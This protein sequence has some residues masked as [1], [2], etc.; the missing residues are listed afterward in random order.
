VTETLEHT[1]RQIAEQGRE[2]LLARLRPAFREAA[3]AH[4]DTLTLDDEQLEQMV[5]RAA[6]RADGLQWRRALASVA[7]E[8]LG[9]GLGEALSHPAVARAQEIVGAPSYEE[10]LS[11]LGSA[12]VAPAPPPAAAEAAPPVQEESRGEEAQAP[13][14]ETQEPEAPE[15]EVQ[16]PEVHE[17]EVQEPEVHE[18][19]AP[20]PEE[21]PQTEARE[22]EAPQPEAVETEAPDLEAPQ[23]EAL[24]TE[25][26]ES[27]MPAAGAEAEALAP[28]EPDTA[29]EPE[30]ES[31]LAA[32][33][34]EDED[35]EQ[36]DEEAPEDVID[37]PDAVRLRAVHL[38]GIAN[39]APAEGDLELHISSAGL[40]IMR[41]PDNAV[42]GRL[43]WADIQTLETPEASGRFRRKRQADAHLVVRSP[44]GTASFEIPGVTPA[45]LR[46]HIEPLVKAHGR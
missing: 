5:Q 16:E 7:T 14:P 4:R 25:P 31:E 3:A 15:P 13:E 32:T 12:P 33:E 20:E 23:P 26:S 9:I 8:Q 44:Q 27:E 21:A 24:E 29:A 2:A 17:P 45:E 22:T 40:D 41:G 30:P 11:A 10:A 43:T 42:L 37:A 38:G 19:E 39:L 18:P 36:E 35:G 1:A 28:V 6:D 46:E 34:Y